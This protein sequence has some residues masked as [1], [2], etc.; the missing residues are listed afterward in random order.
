VEYR[1]LGHSGLRV[2]VVALGAASFGRQCDAATSATIVDRA[3]ELGV[4]FVDTA[5]VYGDG[6]SEE[7]VGR[8]LARRRQDV[9][10]ATKFS[11]P[12]GPGP[13][14]A[15]GSRRYVLQ[16]VQA[17]LRRLRVDYLD[18]YQIHSWDPTT[19]LEE[20]LRA[21][22]DLVRQ[23]AVRYV[24]CSNF[25]AW[26]VVEGQWLAR[27]EHLSPLIS[28]QV[29]YHLLDR[30]V[31]AA[32]VPACQRYG[33]GLLPYFP[34]A[35]GFLSGRFRAGQGLPADARLASARLWGEA[36][37]GQVLTETN[38]AKLAVLERFAAE[39]GR[40]VRELALAWLAAQPQVSSVLAGATRP[41]Q[42]VENVRAFDWRLAA[43]DLAQLDA[44]LAA[45]APPR[46]GA[47]Q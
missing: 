36:L 42:V 21:L 17:S 22:D 31:E 18:L 1:S 9:V 37:A 45:L 40:S 28:L 43:D 2:S 13:L 15:G 19:P 11:H 16:A 10:L 44:A 12:T 5:D 34:L 20:T 38:F 33:V 32:L 7:Y 35:G 6:V 25:R 41:E 23:G 27:T 3:L 30:S 46:P 39:R 24:G 8:A 47:S 29:P 4:N 14:A 26:Q